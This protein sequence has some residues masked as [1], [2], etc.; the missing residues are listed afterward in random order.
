MPTQANE[1]SAIRNLQRYLR[2]L[3]YEE[4]SIIAPPVDGIFES[5]TREAL[6]AFQALKGLPTTGTADQETWELL[7]AA[8]RASLSQSVPPRTVAIFPRV[9]KGLTLTLGSS[10]FPIMAI[11]YMLTELT[12]SY[13][14]LGEFEINGIYDEPT[15]NAVTVFQ[16]HNVLPKTGN[17]DFDTWNQIADQYNVL[18]TKYPEE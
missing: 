2:Q 18:F 12:S 15:K 7:Y 8:Y 11:Q 10:G 13:G 9:P 5:D 6:L 17:V 16:S 4:K 1:S 3:S 14:D